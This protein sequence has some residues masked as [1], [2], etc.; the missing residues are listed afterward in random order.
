MGGEHGH[1]ALGN[2]IN[3]L[4]EDRTP[5]SQRLYNKLVVNDFLAH[6]HGCAVELQGAFHGFHC[7]VNPRA[8]PTWG[9]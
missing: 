7:P 4:N 1:R 2:L 6:V 8:I 3:L 5:I 9:R